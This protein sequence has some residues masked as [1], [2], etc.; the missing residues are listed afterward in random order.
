MTTTVARWK[1]LTVNRVIF[2]DMLLNW[3]LG[4]IFTFLPGL[5]ELALGKGPLMPP[6]V[7]RVIGI[8]FLVFAGWQTWIVLHRDIGPGGLIVSCIM[9]WAPVLLL[10]A[11]L[12]FGEFPLRFAARIG[13]WVGDIY[14]LFLGAWYLFLARSLSQGPPPVGGRSA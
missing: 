13:L 5:A 3:T 10:T 2:G 8:I 14:M 9:A 4:A 6:A 7:W 11:A 1:R 12:V